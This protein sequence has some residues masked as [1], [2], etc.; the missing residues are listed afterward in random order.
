VFIQGGGYW[1]G[2]GT[3]SWTTCYPHPDNPVPSRGPRACRQASYA[4]VEAAYSELRAQAGVTTLAYGNLYMFGAL[5]EPFD[6]PTNFTSACTPLPVDDY[7]R[8]NCSLNL[9]FR[10]EQFRHAALYNAGTDTQIVY[11]GYGLA[12][13]DPAEPSYRRFMVEQHQKQ[14]DKTPSIVGVA[15]DEQQYLGNMNTRRDDGI[16]W[17]AGKPAAS[18]LRSF[19]DVTSDIATQVLH[20]TGR[21]L[22]VN[23]HVYRL[24]MFRQRE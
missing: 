11:P 13:V 14:V 4:Q 10:S 15:F 22:L 6:S 3:D 18:L 20:P 17:H 21:G 16:A 24:D 12:V 5:I 2:P 7:Q 19:I 9:Q 1:L 23:P 8:L